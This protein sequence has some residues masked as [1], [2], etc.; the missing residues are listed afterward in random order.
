MVVRY[1]E[2]S[3]LGMSGKCCEEEE[4]GVGL[5]E[6]SEEDHG[7]KIKSMPP[8]RR[9]LHLTRLVIATRANGCM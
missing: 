4:V 2:G 1:G 3:V 9:V 7:L 5:G 6:A 8:R